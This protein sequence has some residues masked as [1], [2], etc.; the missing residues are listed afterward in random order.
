[1][2]V[3][4]PAYESAKRL[5]GYFIE[6]PIDPLLLNDAVSNNLFKQR[7]LSEKLFFQREV[8]KGFDET[9]IGLF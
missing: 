7:Q 9:G 3:P 2:W 6:K 8:D 4:S 1:M 5:H